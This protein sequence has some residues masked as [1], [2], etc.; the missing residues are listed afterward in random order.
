[1]NSTVGGVVEVSDASIG[2]V[3]VVGPE[4][5]V[6]HPGLDVDHE[7][8]KLPGYEDLLGHDQDSPE[9]VREQS[10]LRGREAGCTRSPR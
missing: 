4:Q 3:L 7:A 10:W 9:S 8:G 1:M 6:D 5:L 2:E